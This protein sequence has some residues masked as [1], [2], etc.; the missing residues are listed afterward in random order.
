MTSLLG[1]ISA[2]RRAQLVRAPTSAAA[3]ELFLARGL[4]AAAGVRQ[5]LAAAAQ[6][7]PALR[8]VDG[9]FMVIRQ[10]AAV[11]KGREVGLRYLADLVE[12]AK[13]SGFVARALERSGA[14]DVTVAPAR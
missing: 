12:E 3:I 1:R 5:A 2:P 6:K 13:A 10:A 7:D 11:P 8:L 14:S 4:D 9:S